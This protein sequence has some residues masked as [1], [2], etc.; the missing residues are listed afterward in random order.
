LLAMY[1]KLKLFTSAGIWRRLRLNHRKSPSPYFRT[2]E[3][4]REI[5]MITRWKR[6]EIKMVSQLKRGE[7]VKTKVEERP[8]ITP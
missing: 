1:D 2:G 6:R 7:R 5:K 3:E 4:T 8:R